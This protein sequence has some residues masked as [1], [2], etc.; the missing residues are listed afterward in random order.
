MEKRILEL[1]DFWMSDAF[2]EDTRAEVKNLRENDPKGLEDAFYKDLAFGTGGLRGVMGAGTNRMNV[3]VVSMATQGLANYINKTIESENK[4][5]A[6]AHD[7]RINSH[8]F[9]KKAAEV[10][11]ANGIK[12]YLDRKSVV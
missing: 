1:A 9:A 7:S 11:S 4:S 12:A 10:L 8:V 3:Y 2:D 5:V 6:I